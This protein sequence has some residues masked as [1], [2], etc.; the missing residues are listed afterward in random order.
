M[1]IYKRIYDASLDSIVGHRNF[2]GTSRVLI[3]SAEPNVLNFKSGWLD[4][5]QL[6]SAVNVPIKATVQDSLSKRHDDRAIPRFPCAFTGEW[7]YTRPKLRESDGTAI[8]RVRTH[9]HARC[10]RLPQQYLPRPCVS[11]KKVWLNICECDFPLI[12]NY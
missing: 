10:A 9:I 1:K 2:S 8:Y 5:Y 4:A 11:K 6:T 3:K 7:K 12:F